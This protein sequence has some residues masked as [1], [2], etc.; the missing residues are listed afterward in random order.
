MPLYTCELCSY[1]TKIKTQYKRHLNTKK[2]QNN[3]KGLSSKYTKMTSKDFENIPKDF[4]K[5]S[6]DFEMTSK[7]F[8]NIPNDFET[9]EKSIKKVYKISKNENSNFN[10]VNLDIFEENQN[11]E[12]LI[13][14]EYC[15]QTF[16]RRNNLTTHLKKNRC[17]TLKKI[18]ETKYK[19]LYEIQKEK[20]SQY[21]NERDHLYKQID[22]L[23]DKVGD[24]NITQNIMLNCYGKEDLSHIPDMFKLASLKIPYGMIPKMIEEVHFS[25]KCPANK[26]ILLP[27]K[28]QPFVKI[29][30][31]D[32]WIYKD[33]KTTIKEL[34][35]RNYLRL[36]NF[37]ELNTTLLD[38][39]QNK[40]YKEF[41]KEKDNNNLD[42]DITKDIEIV[43]MN[44][45]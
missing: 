16:T 29:Y 42:D 1:N 31:K 13:Q 33:K 32:K 44:K 6:K 3:L 24:T 19:K 40:R 43:L 11:N 9:S 18:E 36:N 21:E 12:N 23:L 14:C 15:Y 27:N 37:Y 5:T 28:K 10:N 2:H 34:I 30:S 25:E 45:S 35:D 7:D 17:K 41:C 39:N 20:I 26:N 38:G 22:K 8:E 4:E